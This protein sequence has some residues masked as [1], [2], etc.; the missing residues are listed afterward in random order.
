MLEEKTASAKFGPKIEA[1]KRDA[2]AAQNGGSM[3]HVHIPSIPKDEA[4]IRFFGA[5][6]NQLLIFQSEKRSSPVGEYKSFI[7]AAASRPQPG[8]ED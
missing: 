3:E 2:I 4:T 5:H 1:R 8:H 6:L 7:V